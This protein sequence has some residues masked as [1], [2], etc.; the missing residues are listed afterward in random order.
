V[1]ARV[2]RYQIVEQLGAGGMGVV[3]RA[4]DSELGRDVALKLVTTE[5]AAVGT[6]GQVRLLREA[7][8]LAQLSHPNVIAIYDVGRHEDGVFLAMELVEGQRLDD[9]LKTPRRWREIVRAFR[10]AGHGL[11]AAHA[12][13]LVHRDIK[14][15]NLMVAAD[16][17]V[18]VLDFG[19]A[20]AAEA[21]PAAEPAAPAADSSAGSSSTQNLLVAPLTQV[22]SI[23]G[24]PPYMAPEQH[25][26][27]AGDERSDQFSFCVTLYQA[28]Y[29][30]RPFAGQSYDELF[31]NITQGQIRPPPAGASV[32]GWVRQILLRGLSTAPDRRWPSMGELLT[33]LDRD[34]A[35]RRRRIASASAAVGLAATA[36]FGLWRGTHAA[37]PCAGAAARLSGVWDPARKQAVR[38][39]FEKTGKPYAL[40]VYRMVERALD[41]YTQ[42]WVGMHSDACEATRVRGEQSTE[43]L[44]LRMQCLQTRLD[45]VK[46]K[47][48]LF[49][50]ADAEVVRNASSAASAL[51][52]LSTCADAA[53]L[54]APV[55][56]PTDP[57]LRARAGAL[58][59]QHAQVRALLDV[60]RYAEGLKL[61]ESA[62]HE[63]HALGHRPVEAQALLDLGEVQEDSGDYAVAARTLKDA[64]VAGEAGRHDEVAALAS[65][66]LV[67]VTGARLGKPAEAHELERDARAKIERLGNDDLILAMLEGHVSSIYVDEAKFDAALE[68]AQRALAIR[69]KRLAPDDPKLA[70]SLG[71]LGDI[72]NELRHDDQALDYYRRAI[73]I[74]EKSLGPAHD[75]AASLRTNLASTLRRQGRYD[76]ALAEYERARQIFERALGPDHPQLA[77][78][79]L[80]EGEALQAQ[81]KGAAAREHFL[82]AGELWTRALGPAHA[83]LGTVHFRLGSL[84]LDEGH[85]PDALAEMQ[86]ALEIWR[87][88]LGAEHPTVSIAF[89]GRGDALLAAGRAKEALGEYQHAVTLL[90]RYLGPEHPDLAEALTGL[91][92]AELKLGQA[93]HALAPL[94][95][96]LAIRLK[97]AGDPLDLAK[98]RFALAR[99]LGPKPRARELAQSAREAFARPPAREPELAAVDAWLS[100][101]R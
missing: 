9:W 6:Q 92:L 15:S 72:A 44:D 39:A 81:R 20:R 63:A 69:E 57:Q 99:A 46:A 43:L 59:K 29:G 8:A 85:V 47:V 14:P 87:A 7:Q 48:D 96:A 30:E 75:Q 54:R 11:Q 65:V 94:E 24:T 80:D 89:K 70:A 76:E 66:Q 27:R 62:M 101:L 41:A 74:V 21:E 35:V 26:G 49:A 10:D 50:A 2:G 90:E 68:H 64:E 56:I 95:R 52:R 58:Q 17:R 37:R 82:R 78:V 79:F 1:G 12:V 18:R 36:A 45:E 71:D 51:T 5:A 19:L 23:V 98:T 32:P 28:L 25:L 97:S 4:R 34:P 77:T 84:A 73:A 16:G 53:A 33:A 60:G 38:D 3:Y 86:R 67:W 83:N 91:G 31:T 100:R 93:E 61:A 13:G 22:G 88:A 55:P 42:A 40:D